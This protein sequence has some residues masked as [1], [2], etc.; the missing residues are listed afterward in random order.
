MKSELYENSK[1]FETT[2]RPRR[3]RRLR[4]LRMLM[5]ETRLSTSDMMYPIFVDRRISKR[6]QV[7]SMPG[8]YRLPIS[9]L[10]AGN[11]RGHGS[12]DAGHT[13]FRIAGTQGCDG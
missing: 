5:Q 3:L 9:D 2:E 10:K 12:E 7:E 6:T 8:I 4:A 1:E 11:F 13:C